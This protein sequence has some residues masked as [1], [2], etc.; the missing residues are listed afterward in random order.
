MNVFFKT[1]FLV[2]MCHR[3]ANGSKINRLYERFLNIKYCD[4]HPSSET[5]LEKDGF[6]SIHNRNIKVLATEMYKVKKGFSSL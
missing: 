2:W 6:V 3:R 4:K 1:H 5:L